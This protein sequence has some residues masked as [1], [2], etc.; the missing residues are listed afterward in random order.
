MANLSYIHLNPKNW[1]SPEEFQPERFLDEFGRFCNN[2]NLIPFSVGKRACLGQSM[3]EQELFLF[4]AGFLHRFT[5]E[6]SEDILPD[7]DFA[8]D[9]CNTSFIRYPPNYKV[10]IKPRLI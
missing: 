1:K 4:L 6:K 9:D 5:F 3:A 7:I 10:V 2:E 8:Q